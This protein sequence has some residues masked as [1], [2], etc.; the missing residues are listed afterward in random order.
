MMIIQQ[1]DELALY[2]TQLKETSKVTK[3]RSTNLVNGV[4]INLKHYLR[5]FGS[6]AENNNLDQ[7]KQT[8]SVSR[9]LTDF[10]IL[11]LI[12]LKITYQLL[13]TTNNI[14]SHTT[15]AFT[16]SCHINK[17]ISLIV[18]L[19]LKENANIPILVLYM[20]IFIEIYHK[21]TLFNAVEVLQNAS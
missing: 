19:P 5:Q 4:L 8:N 2:K 3:M 14:T 10:A 18:R 6:S 15:R 21:Y 11:T 16:S 17:L 1:P 9:S 20:L 13:N 12:Y 7:L